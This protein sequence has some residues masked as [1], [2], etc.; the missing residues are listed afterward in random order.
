M[1]FF[2]IGILALLLSACSSANAPVESAPPAG[3]VAVDPIFREFYNTLGGREVLGY[4]IAPATR[5]TM[6]CQYTAAALMCYDPNAADSA[7]FSLQPI[8]ARMVEREQPGLHAGS[9]GLEVDGY[10]INEAFVGLYKRLNGA[11]YVGRPLT[12]ARHNPQLQRVEQFFENL[13]FYYMMDDPDHS[14][15]LIAYGDIDCHDHCS[16]TPPDNST[17]IGGQAPSK[18]PFLSTIIR[19]NAVGAFGQPLTGPYATA[20][21]GL[22]QVYERVVL[23]VAADDLG[24]V[25]LRPTAIILGKAF[26]LPGEQRN[27]PRLVFYPVQ[28]GLGYNVPK[29]FDQFIA[30]HGGLEISGRPISELFQVGTQALY[31]QCFENYC[32]DY[33]ATQTEDLRVLIAPLGQEYVNLKG[34][35]GEAVTP[36]QFTPDTVILSVGEVQPQIAADAEQKVMMMVV[37]RKDQHPIPNIEGELTLF[38]PDGSTYTAYFPPTG[39]N[40]LSEVTIPAQPQLENGT[41]LTYQV[42]VNGGNIAPVCVP[43]SYLI[44]NTQ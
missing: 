31:R 18:Q 32:L 41:L 40:G 5:E 22:E 30:L 27:D 3:T 10:V 2:V 25:R 43:E 16:Y 14:V 44:W 15:R 37:Q 9:G 26:S 1:V 34:L 33:D 6:I 19:L 13:G 39:E 23:F 7:R 38:L 36:F 4:A 21:G 11:R 24:T 12:D 42:C 28:G 8:G 35:G 17:I 29:I 20:D